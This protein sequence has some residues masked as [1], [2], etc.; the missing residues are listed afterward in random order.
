MTIDKKIIY[1]LLLALL[2]GGAVLLYSISLDDITY[3]RTVNEVLDDPKKFT[4][5]D[6]RVMGLVEP[7][8]VDWEPTDLTLQFRITEDGVNFLN[9]SFKGIKPDLFKE[10]QGVVAEGKMGD[11]FFAHNLLVKHSPEYSSEE[12]KD[13]KASYYK[14]LQEGL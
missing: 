7:G 14:T 5:T 6:I 11:E 3:Y 10:G 12:H 1:F 8:S 9:V 4:K 13:D 2:V